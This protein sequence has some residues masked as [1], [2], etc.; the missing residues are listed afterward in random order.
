[1]T[2]DDVRQELEEYFEGLDA[3]EL[4][5]FDTMYKEAI[6]DY[7][8]IWYSADTFWDLLKGADTFDVVVSFFNGHDLDYA[9]GNANANPHRD[10][11]SYNA[12]GN[13]MSTDY[14]EDSIEKEEIIDYILE[15][16]ETFGD[17]EIGDILD[18][19][20]EGED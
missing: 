4:V 10:W 6:N 12:Y 17:N 14:V 7:D 16:G 20:S 3:A 19:L 1:M 15:N 2:R 9:S 5:F 13:V 18:R 8:S 11:F